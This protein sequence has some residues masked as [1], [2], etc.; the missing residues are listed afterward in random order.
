LPAIGRKAGAVPAHTSRDA[1]PSRSAYCPDAAGRSSPQWPRS[2][3]SVANAH[4]AETATPKCFSAASRDFRTP[5]HN[6]KLRLLVK[7]TPAAAARTERLLL[8]DSADPLGAP[9][10]LP[11]DAKE[12]VALVG[13][14][15]AKHWR[16]ALNV[17]AKSRGWRLKSITLTGCPLSAAPR[18]LPEPAKSECVKW[19]QDVQAWFVAHP[20][21]QTVFVSGLAGG[22][23]AIVPRG[24][25]KYATEVAG[26]VNAWK[27]L[28]SVRHRRA[29][30]HAEELDTTPACVEKALRKRQPAG[31]VCAFPRAKN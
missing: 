28:P 1:P 4:G 18:N 19:N 16:G 29:P 6:P 31:L 21:V 20:E 12:S 10:A 23:G 24:Q 11:Q 15:H 5:C 8:P 14:S 9:G 2:Q 17:V 26:Y 22:T 7:P 3:S 25:S 13:D 27:A 30:G